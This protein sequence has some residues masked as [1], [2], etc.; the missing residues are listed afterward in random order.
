LTVSS[1]QFGKEDD[2]MWKLFI[3]LARFE[4][5]QASLGRLP[6]QK[7]IEYI[8]KLKKG[9]VAWWLPDKIWEQLPAVIKSITEA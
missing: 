8:A 5:A 1:P 2:L 9:S 3:P 4:G 7:K 6:K